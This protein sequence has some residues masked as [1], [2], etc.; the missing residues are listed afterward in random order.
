[1]FDREATEKYIVDKLN[2]IRSDLYGEFGKLGRL[3]ISVGYDW[4]NVFSSS[5]CDGKPEQVDISIRYNADGT[6]MYRQR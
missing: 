2:E 1:M 4:I 3:N 6:E 5:H